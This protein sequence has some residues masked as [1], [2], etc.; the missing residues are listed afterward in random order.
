MKIMILILFHLFYLLIID[1]NVL[2]SMLNANN[3]I[4]GMI[5]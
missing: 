5:P 2:I 4:H 1:M 3:A